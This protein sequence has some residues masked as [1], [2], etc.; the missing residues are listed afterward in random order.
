VHG[1]KKDAER[2]LTRILREKD[3]GAYVEPSK[4]TVAEYLERWLADYAKTNT[5][6]KTYERYCDIARNHIIPALGKHELSK[7]KPLQIQSYYSKAL[8]SGRRDGSGGLASQTVL[9]HHRLLRKAMQDAV[10][11]ELISRNPVASVQPP[12]TPGEEMQVLNAEEVHKL[13]EA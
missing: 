7:L 9:H 6:G 3:T 1:T 4:M 13:L 2:E 10:K 5:S 12:R 8:Q 11:W